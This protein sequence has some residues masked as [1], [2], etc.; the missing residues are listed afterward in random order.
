M[1]KPTC[2]V[3]YLVWD[4]EM[5]PICNFS[6]KYL[7]AKTTPECNSEERFACPSHLNI[8]IRQLGGNEWVVAEISVKE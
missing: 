3:M 5:Q 8:V 1:D 7:I 4:G 6:P 2:Q